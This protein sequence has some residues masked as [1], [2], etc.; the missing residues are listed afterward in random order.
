MTSRYELPPAQGRT[1]E[2]TL[3]AQAGDGSRTVADNR[4]SCGRCV[5]RSGAPWGNL[6]ER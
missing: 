5:L 1:T 6:P 2:G 4:P 3:P